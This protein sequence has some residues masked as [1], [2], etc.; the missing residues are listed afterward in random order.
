[1][2]DYFIPVPTLI[3]SI[4]GIPIE[5]I[6]I[7]GV[8][9]QNFGPHIGV[10]DIH[11]TWNHT[12]SSISAEAVIDTEI[13]LKLGDFALIAGRADGEQTTFRFEMSSSRASLLDFLGPDAAGADPAIVAFL[14]T[15]AF[16]K[17]IRITIHDLGF[18]L[19][20][21]RDHASSVKGLWKAR[22]LS[23]F[24]QYHLTSRSISSCLKQLS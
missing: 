3:P 15:D 9:Y 5:D 24:E 18:R 6:P 11:E 8:F 23:A 4:V 10:R 12:H 2:S 1:M 7:I 17:N 19:R 16:P 20:L 14:H 22:R 21:P 13:E